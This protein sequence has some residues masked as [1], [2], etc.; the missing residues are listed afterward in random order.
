[1]GLDAWMIGER[2]QVSGRALQLRGESLHFRVSVPL[3]Q[4]GLEPPEL[5]VAKPSVG[6][7][8]RL[9]PH[10]RFVEQAPRGRDL[11]FLRKETRQ[12]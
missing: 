6:G 9:E 7:R 3:R 5:P 1:M 4:Y 10:L 2:E 12:L 8:V 11:P